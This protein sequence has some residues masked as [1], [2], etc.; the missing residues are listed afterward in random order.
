VHR[1]IGHVIDKLK[2]GRFAYDAATMEQEGKRC[3]EQERRADDATRDVEARLKAT[4][5]LD[6]IGQVLPGTVTGVTHFGLFVTLDELFVDGLV[7]VTALGRDYFH[8]TDGGSRL[9]GERSGMSYALGDA[10]SV[11]VL[12]VDVDEA[13]IDFALADKDPAPARRKRRRGR[14]RG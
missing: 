9:A 11:E 4:W 5:L 2:P 13:K 12:R 10:V 1:G 14:R 7:H 8:L 3:S 6:R